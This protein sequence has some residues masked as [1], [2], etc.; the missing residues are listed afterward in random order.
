MWVGVYYSET[1]FLQFLPGQEIIS[2]GGSMGWCLEYG[3]NGGD[4]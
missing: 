1:S 4:T 3:E 2:A